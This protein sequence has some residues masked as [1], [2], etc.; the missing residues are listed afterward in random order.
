MRLKVE[1]ARLGDLAPYANNSKEHPSWQVE[2]IANSIDQFG[3]ND[4]VGVWTN[5]DGVLEIVEGHG[6]VLACKELGWDDDVKV[7]IVKLDH[8]D[9]H[10]R[11]AYVHVH[12][13]TTLTSGLDSDMLEIDMEQLGEFDW[14][15]FG[16]DCGDVDWFESHK[17]ND[18]SQQDGNDEYN[19]FLE[20]FETK[21][22]TD[23][24]YTPDE[25]YDVVL[26]WVRQEYDIPESA[27]IIRP[28]YPG[29]DY[30]NEEYPE[31]C[32]VV[33]NPPFSILSEI[34]RFYQDRG[35]DFFMFCPSLTGLASKI[36]GVC[37]VAV[38]ASVTYEN[39][40]V[41]NT[42]FCTNLE[43]GI[44][45]RTAPD[46]NRLVCDADAR[47]YG[48]PHEQKPTRVYPPYV[49]TSANLIR[50]SKY[51]VEYK[52]SERESAFVRELDSCKLY[53][54]GL[55][56]SERAKEEA[57]RAREEAEQAKEKSEH[58]TLSE[59]EMELIRQLDSQQ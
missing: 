18:R 12:N 28:F 17:R 10:A 52:V 40:A 22:T 20:K 27:E 14:E 46:L 44:V 16:F 53:G 2:N 5:P 29:G 24:C 47:C 50:L 48:T 36:D 15:A 34:K 8:L 13:Q 51:G 11:R 41:V 23:D 35:I 45:A 4:P 33:D 54:G 19:K 1:Y 37:F 57:E 43:D 38:D 7:P 55:L 42:S 59:K 3:F 9:D 25:V 30:E 39:G 49:M 32:I 56:L 26:N 58:V 21:K 6:R 31:G